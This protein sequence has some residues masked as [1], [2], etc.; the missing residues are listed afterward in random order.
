[1]ESARWAP[2]SA[3]E[4]A[5]RSFDERYDPV[6]LSYFS[7][8][9]L[10]V[11]GAAHDGQVRCAVV[12]RRSG[13]LDELHV[14]FPGTA[15]GRIRLR[16]LARI[17]SQRSAPG[18]DSLGFAGGITFISADWSAVRHLEA[19]LQQRSFGADSAAPRRNRRRPV[20]AAFRN[21][22]TAAALV[23]SVASQRIALAALCAVEPG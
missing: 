21:R 4:S 16:A 10:A 6:L 18:V 14:V 23:Q 22:S 5:S 3:K 19:S 17:A 15:A 1:M 20:F 8:C 13:S 9:L 12:R 2:Q 11:P 7:E